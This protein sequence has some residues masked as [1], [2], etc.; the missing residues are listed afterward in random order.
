MLLHNALSSSCFRSGL[1]NWSEIVSLRSRS[2]I[3][4]VPQRR[5]FDDVTSDRD[6]TSRLTTS[7]PDTSP[8]LKSGSWFE[9]FS[10]PLWLNLTPPPQKKEVPDPEEVAVTSSKDCSSGSVA[11]IGL[12]LPCQ[13]LKTCYRGQ[14]PPPAPP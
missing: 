5:H 9:K 13:S 4:T 14:L 12:S 3:L 8:V 1:Y 7:F 2:V 6:I 11:V 10:W